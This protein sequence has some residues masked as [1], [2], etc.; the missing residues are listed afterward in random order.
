VALGLAA[1]AVLAM[2]EGTEQTP[3]AIITDVSFVKF[4]QRDPTKEELEYFYIKN[5]EEDLFAPFLN[6][7]KWQKGKSDKAR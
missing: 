3:I 2:G 7:V 1:A 4:Q 5:K 6:A